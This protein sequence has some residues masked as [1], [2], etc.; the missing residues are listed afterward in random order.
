MRLPSWRYRLRGCLRE[1]VSSVPKH[2][3]ARGL[4]EQP[5]PSVARRMLEHWALLFANGVSA[6][7]YYVLNLHR[8]ELPWR[9]K[10]EFAGSINEVVW[11]RALNPDS[12]SAVTEDK[13]VFK[14]YL[15]AAGLPMARTYGVIGPQGHS[16][17]G[18]PVQSRDQ[19]RDWLD[20]TGLENIVLKPCRG[21]LGAGV[22][23]LGR[24]Q[25]D[26]LAWERLPDGRATF[27]DVVAHLRRY[28][29]QPYFLVEERL[30]PHSS[31]ASLA[32][33]VLHTARVV[34]LLAGEPRVMDAALRI[35]L[36]DKAVDNFAKG[37]LVAPI[38]I[39]T[40]Q[41]GSAASR[42]TGSRRL[43]AHPVSGGQIEGMVVP[44]WCEVLDL[45]RRAALMMPF[46]PCLGWDVALTPRGPVLQEANDIWDP[47][48]VQLANDRG[49]LRSPLGEYLARQ[50]VTSFL[51][52]R[53]R[54]RMP[55]WAL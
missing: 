48:V 3:Q 16:E 47:N 15:S 6:K 51:G 19:L 4:P 5:L 45:V 49:L 40:G 24:R 32:P 7:D 25:D 30:E 33:R 50:G 10:C 27:A 1:V 46:N 31:L 11:L 55:S 14:R 36:G 42:D 54:R 21:V 20:K 34:T 9:H 22:I 13:L 23:V 39:A 2:V 8:R 41:V 44:D 26:D 28:T 53:R 12:Y 17:D 37:N 52:I 18:Q 43:S 35:G 29:H 38:D